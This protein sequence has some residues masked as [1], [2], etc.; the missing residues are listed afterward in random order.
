MAAALVQLLMAAQYQIVQA[1]NK[2]AAVASFL[3]ETEVVA[4]AALQLWQLW[5]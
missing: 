5:I 4:N 1:P 2:V 3:C